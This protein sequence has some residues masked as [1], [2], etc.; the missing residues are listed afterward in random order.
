MAGSTRARSGDED[1]GEKR[2]DATYSLLDH[3]IVDP[4]GHLA[5]KV[6]DV[7]LTDPGEG[8]DLAAMPPVVTAIL[9]G[10]EALGARLGGRLGKVVTGVFHRLHPEEDPRPIRITPDEVARLTNQLEITV[11]AEDVYG[12]RSERWWSERFISGL[13]GA[14]RA[15]E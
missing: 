13:P 4:N 10:P 1:Q 11:S 2:I 3:Q 15:T 7:E 8:T 12:R 14:D 6:D 9:S 5:G